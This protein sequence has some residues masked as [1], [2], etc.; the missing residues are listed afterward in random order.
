MFKKRVI[1]GKLRSKP[2]VDVAGEE[3]ED[4]LLQK[5]LDMREEQ[6]ERKRYHIAGVLERFTLS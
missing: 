3:E 2:D 4:S 1:K 5:A 6:E